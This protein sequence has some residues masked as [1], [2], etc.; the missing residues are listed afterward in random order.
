MVAVSACQTSV[1]SS[2]FPK[3]SWYARHKTP[4]RLYGDEMPISNEPGRVA[5]PGRMAPMTSTSGLAL[6]S[7]RQYAASSAITAA[8]LYP[9]VVRWLQV[10]TSIT[11]RPWSS[12]A[13]AVRRTTSW[14]SIG[15]ASISPVMYRNTLRACG[16]SAAI[17][18]MVAFSPAA[19]KGRQ[20]RATAVQTA[21]RAAI[22]LFPPR[23]PT[24]HQTSR[25]ELVGGDDRPVH[26]R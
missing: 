16:R 23:R 4:R 10:A 7:S 18:A 9:R 13:L 5:S 6:L 22:R 11:T 15:T 17:T 21:S 20:F 25:V 8:K 12:M 1:G 24:T 14:R 19:R 3:W 26:R 2:S